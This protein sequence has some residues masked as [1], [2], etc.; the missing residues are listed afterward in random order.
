[1]ATPSKKLARHA[2]ILALLDG[3]PLLRVNEV[4]A[5]LGVS[6]ETIRRDLSE[7]EQTGRLTRT[8]GG[9]VRSDG[10]EPALTERLKLHVPQR[11]RIANKALEF[12][13]ETDVLFIGGGATPLHF[14][15]ALREIKR[16]ITVITPAF[17][18]ANELSANPLIQVMALPGIVEPKEG[19]VYGTETLDTIRKYRPPLAIIGASGICADGVSEALMSAAQVYATMI[20]NS[21]ETLVLADASKFGH[22]ALQ[23]VTRWAPQRTLICDTPPDSAL[24]TAIR[25]AGAQWITADTQ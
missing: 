14:A 25:D 20:Q 19:L 16:R 23:V 21:Q 11:Q 5:E 17:A 6:S 22:R 12:L 3:N 1:M 13:N 7:L 18:I 8:Y 4:A 9:A 24:D 10:I 15:R 2:R